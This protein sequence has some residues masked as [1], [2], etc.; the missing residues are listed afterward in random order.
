[1][2]NNLLRC[3]N[4]RILLMLCLFAST[5]TLQA[6]IIRGRVIDAET[7]EPLEG[8]QV[9]VLEIRGDTDNQIAFQTKKTTDSL[10]VFHYRCGDMSQLV[11]TANYFGYHEGFVRTIGMAGNDTIHIKDIRLKPSPLLLKEIQVDAKKR[12][13]YMRG[14]TVVFNPEAFDLEEGARLGELIEKLPGV[15]VKDGQ[16]L[17]N[18][19]PLKL[20]MNGKEAFEP[21]MFQKVLPIEAVENIKAYDQKSELEERTG[22]ADGKQE[23]VLDVSIKPQFMDKIYGDAVA[24]AFSSGNYAAEMNAMRLSDTDPFMLFGR[25]SDEPAE[26]TQKTFSSWGGREDGTPVEQQMGTFAYQHD[27]KSNIPALRRHNRWSLS[28]SVN[29]TDRSHE[30]WENTETFLPNTTPTQRNST[31][32]SNA[33]SLQVPINFSSYFN[34]NAKSTLSVDA[35]VTYQYGK[36]DGHN[37]QK[38]FE[39]GNRLVNASTYTFSRTGKNFAGNGKAEL[40]YYLANGLVGTSVNLDYENKDGKGI[41]LGEYHYE[42]PS[43][44]TTFDRQS[45]HID[46]NRLNAS[47]KA[48]MNHS[49]GEQL[50]T[51]ASLSTAYSSDTHHED[52]LRADSI[53]TS[54]SFYRHNHTWQNALSAG[55]NLNINNFDINASVNLSHQQEQL[56]YQRAALDTIA[57]RN[58]L[59]CNPS[60]ALEYRIKPQMRLKGGIFYTTTPA[61]LLDCIGYTDNTNPLYIQSGNPQLHSSHTFGADIRYSLMLP[62]ASQALDVSLHYNKNYTPIAPVLHYNSQTGVYHA[63]QQNVKGGN[64]WEAALSYDRNLGDHITLRNKLSEVWGRSYGVLTLVDDTKSITYNHQNSSLFSHDVTCSYKIL[65]WLVE[66]RNKLMWNRYTYS[67]A[68]Q[69]DQNIFHNETNLNINYKPGHWTFCLRPLL[70]IDR[71]HQASQMNYNQFLLHAE[72]RYRFLHDR[73]EITL[74]GNDLL[75][76][77][78]R[79]TYNIT[80]TSRTEGGE[81]Y[82]HHYVQLT[83]TYKLD[84]KKD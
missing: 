51:N 55:F 45:Y 66:L 40:T 80:A 6:N 25:I 81:N 67:E 14:D 65:F 32:H 71:G 76:Q 13:F 35:N 31:Y 1:M 54:N 57:K 48:G 30:R 53:D 68:T 47:W 20:M 4:L 8:A 5:A 38:T 16:L 49:F 12:K 2:K 41:S 28:G 15:S 52:R 75:N 42:Q 27:W 63:T 37:E 36:D 22:V 84:P 69:A 59:L 74:S 26:I 44:A 73:A 34:L 43:A 72:A 10:G 82:L 77:A 11:F 29:H 19:E 83:F 21:G 46:G 58:L 3:G 61:N 62:R 50:M 64:T 7:G 18:G 60:L 56:N 79:N 39:E 78:R 33:H 24:S 9:A 17:W 23:H 70:L